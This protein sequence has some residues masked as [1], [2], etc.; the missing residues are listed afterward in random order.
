[1]GKYSLKSTCASFSII[2]MALPAFGQFEGDDIGPRNSSG[3]L[4]TDVVSHN[5]GTT[6]SDVRAFGFRFQQRA[7]DP[8]F[9]DLP[10]FNAP[11]GSGIPSGSMT[12][13]V[14]S[15]LGYWDGAGPFASQQVPSGETLRL[16]RGAS[17]RV[18]G[19]STGQLSALSL[20]NVAS[21]GSIHVHVNAFLQGSDGN[22]VPADGLPNAQPPR[23]AD[24]IEAAAGVYVTSIR[25]SHSTVLATEPLYLIYGNHVDT[26][27][28]NRAI[29]AHRESFAP[30]TNVSLF[31]EETY[32]G[33]GAW[34]SV[35]A[36]STGFVPDSSTSVA[37]FYD[38][39]SAATVS[40]GGTRTISTLQID[41]ANPLTLVSGTLRT[42][43][44]VGRAEVLV[45]NGSHTISAPLHA[46]SRTAFEIGATSTLM[47]AGGLVSGSQVEKS[48][49]GTLQVSSLA[50]SSLKI[51][52]G[53]L[54]VTGTDT[55]HVG[56][57]EIAHTGL[58]D[59][60]RA[61]LL[62][63]YTGA[64]PIASAI[65]AFLDGRITAAGDDGFGLPIILAIA[66]AADLG[67]TEFGGIALD[68][69]V[70]VAKFTYVGDAN[71]DGQV[72]ALDYERVDLAI[73][74]SGVF[75]TAQ[76]D[77]N[78]DGQVDAL[79]YEQI[80]LNIGNGVGM[81]LEIEGLPSSVFIPEPAS[82][83]PA[84]VCLCLLRRRR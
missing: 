46:E 17:N 38:L 2:A 15:S 68:E 53:V 31:A 35:T 55:A 3:K 41:S 37:N 43:V 81:P 59:L 62:V 45:R 78:Y 7:N 51:F 4:V 26:A 27:R 65:Q 63:D 84:L 29:L 20:G 6:Q 14:L 73:G 76:G 69:T 42:E 79:D 48:G 60:G 80:D 56:A 36:W 10:G 67:L 44:R 8:F 64:S 58:L 40:L 49:G 25:I 9:T 1:M 50:G 74:N 54:A 16:N 77:I 39:A 23:P 18:V 28:L 72:D 83:V 66:E 47:L 32:T 34:D 13:T 21:N 33:T 19:A 71:L 11:S 52:D 22:S 12:F 82:V 5:T 61:S 30:G 57:L 70:V 75:G 24:G